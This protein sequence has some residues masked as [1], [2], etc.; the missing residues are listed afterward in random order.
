MTLSPPRTRLEAFC[1]SL[2]REMLR[3]YMTTQGERIRVDPLGA[4]AARV[5]AERR[6]R[7]FIAR[8]LGLGEEYARLTLDEPTAQVTPKEP[9]R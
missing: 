1:E 5:A 8:D 2:T 3:E 7:E 4:A 9:A 6:V